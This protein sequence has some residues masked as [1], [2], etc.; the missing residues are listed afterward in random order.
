MP[1]GGAAEAD[2]LNEPTR[3]EG[4]NQGADVPGEQ[5]RRPRVR[6]S[7]RLFRV[8]RNAKNPPKT[9]RAAEA[10]AAQTGQP[11]QGE[12]SS[13]NQGG[14]TR[15][16]PAKTARPDPLEPGTRGTAGTSQGG[17]II[18][19]QG[20]GGNGPNWR[21]LSFNERTAHPDGE[22]PTGAEIGR[23]TGR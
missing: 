12:G 15:E 5:L 7:F 21:F 2:G 6:V 1:K 3:T 23:K 14:R 9:A 22:K 10:L 16:E 17:R 4:G 11:E 19:N 20:R 8:L 13:W 18:W